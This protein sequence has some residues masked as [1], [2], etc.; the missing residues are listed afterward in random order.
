MTIFRQ[1]FPVSWACQLVWEIWKSKNLLEN[2]KKK[3]TKN[4]N[5]RSFFP[6]FQTLEAG[7]DNR[8]QLSNFCHLLYSM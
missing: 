8:K 4:D 6:H 3:T 7:L 5:F 2:A 1:F